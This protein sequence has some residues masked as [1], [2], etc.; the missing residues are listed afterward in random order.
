ME[1]LA[2]SELFTEEVFLQSGLFLGKGITVVPF[3]SR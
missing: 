1:L 2:E 3:K